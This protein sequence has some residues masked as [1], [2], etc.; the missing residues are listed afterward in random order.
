[1]QKKFINFEFKDFWRNLDKN[2][3]TGFLI[4]FFLGLFFH[5]LL[6]LLWQGKD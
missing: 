5:Y 2:I 4:L 3:L 6:L 1:M